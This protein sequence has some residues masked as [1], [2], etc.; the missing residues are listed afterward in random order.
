MKPE[1]PD[2]VVESDAQFLP[3]KLEEHDYPWHAFVTVGALARNESRGAHLQTGFSR[4]AND[5]QT[6]LKTTA[7]QS[8]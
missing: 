2:A 4:S 8:G 6:G 3:A 5:A 7:R 1:R